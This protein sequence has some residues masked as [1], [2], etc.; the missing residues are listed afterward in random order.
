MGKAFGGLAAYG[1]G[2]IT[3]NENLQNAAAEGLQCSRA[4]NVEAL[5]MML[6]VG[7]GAKAPFG[8]GG[9]PRDP[10]TANYLPL[11]G[12]EGAHTTLG[13]RSGRNGD[14]TQGAT[15]DSQGKFSGR[16]DVT[17]HGRADHTNPHWHPAVGPNS[18]GP[19]QPIP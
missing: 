13:T 1:W 3:G 8:K 14:Y 18:V 9:P 19:Q 10:K 16:T 15:F 2:A 6:S 17:N 11:P 12:A 7:K 5:G 4:D